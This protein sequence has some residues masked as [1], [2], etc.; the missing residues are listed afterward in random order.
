MRGI[1]DRLSYTWNALLETDLVKTKVPSKENVADFER[2]LN[3]VTPM[4]SQEKITYDVFRYLSSVSRIGFGKFLEENRVS[5]L[6]LACDGGM[7]VNLLGLRD[8]I[9]LKWEVKREEYVVSGLEDVQV[10]HKQW[11]DSPNPSTQLQSLPPRQKYTERYDKT[12]RKGGGRGDHRNT[13]RYD[14]NERYDKTERKGDGRGDRKVNERYEK[15]ERK[16]NDRDVKKAQRGQKYLPRG[17]KREHVEKSV[18]KRVESPV[19]TSLP[20]L[21]T[22][23][24]ADILNVIRN[25]KSFSDVANTPAIASTSDITTDKVVAF[26]PDGTATPIKI[27]PEDLSAILSLVE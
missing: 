9:N 12:E 13:E 5:F 19:A 1:S 17:D 4:T 24:Q 27:T 8:T 15:T 3:K 26:A 11:G 14:R 7:I 21:S 22:Q 23:I 10:D 25:T 6:S 18:D 16:G 20:P 2:I